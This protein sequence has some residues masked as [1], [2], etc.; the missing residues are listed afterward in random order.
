MR[1]FMYELESLCN[2]L[3]STVYSRRFLLSKNK[4]VVFIRQTVTYWSLRL[5]SGIIFGVKHPKH[6]RTR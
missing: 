6:Y 5:A 2:G 4:R 1:F 3:V